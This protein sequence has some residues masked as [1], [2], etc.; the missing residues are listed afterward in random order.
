MNDQTTLRAVRI[1][2]MAVLGTAREF[3]PHRAAEN[4]RQAEVALLSEADRLPPLS[5]PPDSYVAADL[6]DAPSRRLINAGERWDAAGR[7]VYC[8]V[9]HRLVVDDERERYGVHLRPC[10]WAQLAFA[11]GEAVELDTGE[12]GFK[13]GRQ[14]V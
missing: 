13:R 14:D 8:A 2:T 5:A 6:A 10:L 4:L 9:D 3:D 12:L 1:L 7:C 11:L